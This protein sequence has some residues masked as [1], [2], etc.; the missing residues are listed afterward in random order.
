[1]EGLL[2]INDV[3]KIL[4]VSH[5]T[6][7]KELKEFRLAG[8]KIGRDWRFTQDAVQDY[9]RVRTMKIKRHQS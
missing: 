3:C 5:K 2:K 8:T 7:R 4:N 9:I 1:M 6:V